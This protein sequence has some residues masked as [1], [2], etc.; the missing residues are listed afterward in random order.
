MKVCERVQHRVERF[1][2]LVDGNGVD[3]GGSFR[4]PG[5]A[6]LQK[7]FDPDEINA[8]LSGFWSDATAV[9]AD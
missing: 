5:R 4:G 1:I 7:P 6:S 3:G 2:F 9:Q 8:L